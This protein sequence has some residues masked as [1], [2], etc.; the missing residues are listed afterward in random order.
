MSASSQPIILWH[1][2]DKGHPGEFA[3]NVRHGDRIVQ[4]TR[5]SEAAY[6]A[7]LDSPAIRRPGT[8]AAPIGEQL[9]K[10]KKLAAGKA[11]PIKVTGP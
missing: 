1:G 6:N 11:R 5:L 3:M 7:L 8:D 4:H 9:A 10:A 2:P